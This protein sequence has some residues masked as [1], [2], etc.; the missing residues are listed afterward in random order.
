MYEDL[1]LF[2]EWI[3]KW[4][5][6]IEFKFF[7]LKLSEFASLFT[8]MACVNVVFPPQKIN[9]NETLQLDARELDADFYHWISSVSVVQ[10]TVKMSNLNGLRKTYRKRLCSRTENFA[11]PF[12]INKFFKRIQISDEWKFHQLIKL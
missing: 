5:I 4:V 8:A 7:I 3:A 12:T 2:S 10:F 1:P 11:R 6:V 9:S